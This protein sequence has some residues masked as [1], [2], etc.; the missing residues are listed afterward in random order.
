[1]PLETAT[2]N[3][4]S[5]AH[6]GACLAPGLL[7]ILICPACRGELKLIPSNEL[8]CENDHKFPLID[9]VPCF[10]PLNQLPS[11]WRQYGLSAFKRRGNIASWAANHWENLGLR[12][13]IGTAPKPESSLLCIGGGDIKERTLTEA[14]GFRVVSFDVDPIEGIDMLADGHSLPFQANSFDV[15]TS[16]EVLEHLTAPW[17]AVQEIAR[18]LRP[19]GRFIGSVAFLKPF[20]ESYFHMSHKGIGTLLE[21]VGLHVE[22]IYGGQNV[23]VHIVGRII[24]LGPRRIS[25][26]IYG[27]LFESAMLMRRSVWRLVKKLDPFVPTNLYDAERKL[28]FDA[29]DRLRFGACVIFSASKR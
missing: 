28:S 21:S 10:L 19:S 13:L 14:M 15:V 18:V 9:G 8:H 6:N 24:P 17:I 23:F 1:M 25:N 2:I 22:R 16:F 7:D 29:Y 20:H 5:S 26:A 4:S 12:E 3:L 11:K 27:R